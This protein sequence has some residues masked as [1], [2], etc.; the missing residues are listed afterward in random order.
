M[1]LGLS[2]PLADDCLANSMSLAF[3]SKI[4]S[5]ASANASWTASSAAFLADTGSVARVLDEILAERAACSGDALVRDILE[6]SNSSPSA[7]VSS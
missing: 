7:L 2:S 4:L 5:R 6:L 1:I 3:A